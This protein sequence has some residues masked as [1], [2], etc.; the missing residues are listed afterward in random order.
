MGRCSASSYS[1]QVG[2]MPGPPISCLAWPWGGGSKSLVWE[3]RQCIQL[4]APGIC[5]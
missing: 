4:V 1:H 5:F 3:K 2:P